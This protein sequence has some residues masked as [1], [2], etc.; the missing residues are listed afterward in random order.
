M[1]EQIRDYYSAWISNDIVLLETVMFRN[2]F[3]VRTYREEKLYTKQE[4]LENFE[5]NTIESVVIEDFKEVDDY[6]RCRLVIND[7]EVSAKFTFKEERIYKV[8]EEKTTNNRRIK[9]VVAYDGSSYSGY[10]KQL[11]ASSIQGTIETAIKKTFN[12][13]KLVSIHSSG[14]TDKGVHAVNQVFHFDINSKMKTH[15]ISQV[16]NRYLPDSIYIKSAE[17]VEQTFHSRYDLKVKEYMYKINY[18]EFDPIQINYEWFIKDFDLEVFK[19]ELKSVVG[20][21]DFTTFTKNIPNHINIRTIFDVSI[22]TDD[23]FTY[24]YIKGNGFLRYM[25][26]NIIGAIYLIS[27]GKLDYSVQELIELKDVTLINEKAPASGLYLYD[28]KF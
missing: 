11:N 23:Y 14:R 16:L 21:H 5:S 10:Q 12:Q 20:T 28:V 25:V 15:A 17:E 4:L 9:C 2:I 7:T 27:T 1:I 3:G 26:R 22:K 8:Y 13:D 19:R 24:I 18:R 6:V